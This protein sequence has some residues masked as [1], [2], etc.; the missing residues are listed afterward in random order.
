MQTTTN[1][2]LPFPELVDEADGPAQIEALAQRLDVTIAPLID[3]AR[4]SCGPPPWR[5]PP[6]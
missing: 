5:P 1:F 3:W 2:Q 6:T 4:C